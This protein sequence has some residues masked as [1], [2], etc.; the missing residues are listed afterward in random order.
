MKTKFYM[1]LAKTISFSLVGIGN[2]LFTSAALSKEPDCINYMAEF[3]GSVQ[4]Y[5]DN[6]NPISL[7]VPFN[8][9]TP[10]TDSSIRRR[11]ITNSNIS[12]ACESLSNDLSKS[13]YESIKS[14]NK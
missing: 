9:S 10:E 2:C 8:Y 7:P 3:T 6:F 14:C 13:E 4:C 12:S 11:S 1:T 5:D